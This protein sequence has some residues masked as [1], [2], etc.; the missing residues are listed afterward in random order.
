[1][2][3]SKMMGQMQNMQKQMQEQQE[4]IAKTEVIGEAGAGMVKFTMN[5]HYDALK[6]EIDPS[7]T[8]DM[9]EDDREMLQDVILGAVNAATKQVADKSQNM[10]GGLAGGMPDLGPLGSLFG[11]K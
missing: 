2:D 1:M 7:L 8:G 9:S 5:G 10:M 4:E 3:M 6:L 11:G